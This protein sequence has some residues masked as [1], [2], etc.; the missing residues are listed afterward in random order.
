MDDGS[1]DGSGEL[2]DDYA[3]LDSRVQVLHK[4]NGGLSDARNAG[5]DRATGAYL[6]TID[7]DDYVAPWHIQ[8]MYEAMQS[9]NADIVCCDFV[10]TVEEAFAFP[11]E[12]LHPR[13]YTPM[14]A[15]IAMLYARELFNSA[16]GKLYRR[17]LFD[18]IRYPVGQI[19]EDLATTYRLVEKA[20]RVVSLGACSYAY[21]QREGSIVRSAITQ[22]HM[23][24]FDALAEQ[25]AF[26]PPSDTLSR[27]ISCHYIDLCLD[28]LRS[29][30]CDREVQSLCWKHV[31]RHRRTTLFASAAPWRLRV[32]SLLSYLG[33]GPSVRLLRWYYMRRGA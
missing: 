13:V 29:T 4:P 30:R 14:E 27:A 22:R 33:A 32:F 3:R 9:Q 23:A 15:V 10:R 8:Q 24:A 18:Q 20:N 19:Y 16:W 21:V 5:L 1:T 17:A 25:Q 2:C 28:F 12:I 7:G 26:F 6:L 31:R 11:R